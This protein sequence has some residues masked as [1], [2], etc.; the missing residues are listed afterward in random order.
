MLIMQERT[1]GRGATLSIPKLSGVLLFYGYNEGW[2][3]RHFWHRPV[4]LPFVSLGIF[5]FFLLFYLY[6][7]TLSPM[8]FY[9]LVFLLHIE[10]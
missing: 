2:G 3:K 8:S 4:D 10:E 1:I 5:F 9:D 7:Y 6:Y